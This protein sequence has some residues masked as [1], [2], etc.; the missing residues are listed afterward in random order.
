MHEDEDEDE[1]ADD[2]EDEDEGVDEILSIIQKYVCKQ[3][4]ALLEDL[5]YACHQS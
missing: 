1:Y 5:Y 3:R 2:E 4:C